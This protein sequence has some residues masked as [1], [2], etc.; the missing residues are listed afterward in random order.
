[1]HK[2][3]PP[4]N[5]GPAVNTASREYGDAVESLKAAHLN[6]QSLRSRE[7]ELQARC[8][9][10]GDE[11]EELL[12]VLDDDDGTEDEEYRSEELARLDARWSVTDARLKNVQGKVFQ[13]EEHLQRTLTQVFLP[14][15]QRLYQAFLSH[16]HT[17][18]K[19]KILELVPPDA[20]ALNGTLVDQLSWQTSDVFEARGLEIFV[21]SGVSSPLKDTFPGSP[22]SQQRPQAVAGI[23]A[24]SASAPPLARRLLDAVAAEAGFEPP[25]F[26][27]PCPEPPAQAAAQE[28]V[29]P[30]RELEAALT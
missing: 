23:E 19:A 28:P 13:S 30:I 10:L 9:Q 21:S 6:L 11:R 15:F 8:D 12:R 18:G 20:A 27:P 5:L 25:P 24:A 16:R 7:A 22:L 29:R 17:K 26:H 2:S 3:E 4:P 14:P 1:M